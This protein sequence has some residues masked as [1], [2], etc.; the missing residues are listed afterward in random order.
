MIVRKRSNVRGALL[1]GGLAV[2]SSIALA[3][4]N[5][6]TIPDAQVESNVLKALAT[7]PDLSNQNIQSATVYGTVTLSGNVHDESMRKQAENLVAHTEGVK[8]VIDQMTLGDQPAQTAAAPGDQSEPAA[9]EG[10][11]Q[12]TPGSNQPVLQSDGT[13]APAPNGSGATPENQGDV[14]PAMQSDGAQPPATGDQRQPMNGSMNPGPGQ[15]IPGGQ[16]AG[17]PVTVPAGVLLRIRINRGL[18]AN[19]IQP[20]TSFDATVLTDVVSGGAVAIPRGATVTGTVVD[21]K[22]PGVFKGHGE[23]SLQLDTLTLGGRVYRLPT[24]MWATNGRDKTAGTVNNAVGLGAV[25]ALFGAFVGGGA[26]AAV[27]A[28]IGASAGLANSAGSPR[29]Q[30]IVPPESV[31]SFR[32][33]APVVVRTVSEQEMQRLAYAAGPQRPP[34]PPRIRYYS[35]YYGYYYGPAVY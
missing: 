3:Q 32:L 34:A 17:I 14:A 33:A 29:G 15:P 18:D 25:G 31:L 9:S 6:T 7:A 27:G 10:D 24:Q 35:P 22:K 1:A 12:N 28:G 2:S 30:V 13:Y 4:A 16:Q 5:P 23:L 11:Q 21:A 19:H 8:K 26:G 20:G